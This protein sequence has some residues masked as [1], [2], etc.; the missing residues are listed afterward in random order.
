MSVHVVQYLVVNEMRLSPHSTVY[1]ADLTRGT[2]IVQAKLKI[3]QRVHPVDK[4][5]R[6]AKE[7]NKNSRALIT[8][9][10]STIQHHPCPNTFPWGAIVLFGSGPILA[11][12]SH[13]GFWWS[14][15]HQ[16]PLP[17]NP[18][19]YRALGTG[20]AQQPSKH[21][22]IQRSLQ[23][24]KSSFQRWVA[25]ALGRSSAVWGRAL[26]AVSLN[27]GTQWRTAECCISGNRGKRRGLR[28]S[29]SCRCS[30]LILFLQLSLLLHI[31]AATISLRLPCR[32]RWHLPV[33]I[34]V[35]DEN[36]RSTRK[37]SP[38]GRMKDL[39]VSYPLV[40][41]P[42]KDQTPEPCSPGRPFHSWLSSIVSLIGRP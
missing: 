40:V 36:S 27:R 13:V 14:S 28:G 25:A 21:L 16:A 12:L 5:V 3:T 9:I 22:P 24:P 38:I 37:G 2:R 23:R 34:G 29:L 33:R 20:H 4:S 17:D 30:L 35:R 41:Q 39:I 6:E 7:E 15:Q 32:Y 42:S 18:L 11:V 26:D 10:V 19:L 8:R 31:R 1:V